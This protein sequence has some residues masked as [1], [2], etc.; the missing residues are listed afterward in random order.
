MA[1]QTPLVAAD[2]TIDAWYWAINA[3]TLAVG[4]GLTSWGNA[5]GT[6]RRGRRIT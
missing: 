2:N 6:R 3:A 4:I 1:V 5:V